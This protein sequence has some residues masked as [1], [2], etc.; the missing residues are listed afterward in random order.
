MASEQGRAILFSAE[1]VPVLAGPGK[2]VI[3]LKLSPGDR[4]V[5]AALFG[6]DEARATLTLFNSKG[7]EHTVTKRYDVVGARRPGLPPHQARP[8]GPGPPATRRPR[9]SRLRRHRNALTSGPK[10]ERMK[11]APVVPALALGAALAAPAAVEL[12]RPSPGA[13]VSEKVGT[14]KATVSYHRPAVKGREIWGALVPYGEV[15]RLGANDATTLEI[16]ED[17]KVAGQALPAGT[18]ALFAIPGKASWTIVVNA[19]PKQWGAYF[20]DPKK[21]VLSFPVTPEAGPHQEWLEFRFL[22]ASRSAVR[23]E[24][25]WEKLR[26]AIPRRVRRE[27]HRLEEARRGAGGGRPEGLRRLLPVGALRS[28][29]GRA[30][31]RGDGL[32]GR[33]DGAGATASGWTSSRATSSPTRGSTPRRSRISRRR[34]RRR[35][36]RAPRTSGAPARGRS[37]RAGRERRRADG[38]RPRREVRLLRRRARRRQARPDRGGEE[39]DRRDP[40][41]GRPQRERRGRDGPAS[42]SR[43]STLLEEAKAHDNRIVFSAHGVAPSVRAEAAALG[44]KAIDTTCKFVTDIHTEVARALAEG[45]FIAIMG[46]RTHREVVGYT[47]DLDPSTYEVFYDLA[48]VK[49]FDWSKAQKVR[50]VFQT[51]LN[52]D[53][54]AEH[55]DEIRR[56]VA[57][58]RVADTICYA[59]KENQEALRVLCND[60]TIDA[61]VVIGGRFS[62]NTKELAKI[63]EELQADAPDRHRGRSRAGRSW[64]A[65]GRSA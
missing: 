59:T 44:L 27:R 45:W 25:A 26:V 43:P 40:R 11:I 33:G 21:D 28:R 46:Q 34:S 47:K 13:T 32:A 51:T 6:A 63:A 48:D 22:P 16:T 30:P 36:R 55:V 17:A 41:A 4:V 39:A 20:R 24:M 62:K 53:S 9:R 29:D 60:P 64:R 1:E 65:P 35:R 5:G 8:A 7:T 42:G 57:E 10:E 52:A 38:R 12:P 49:A 2:G 3:G 50:I 58:A 31:R 54:F 18:Y 15:W 37:S 23:L 14:A 56:R 19:D 61:I